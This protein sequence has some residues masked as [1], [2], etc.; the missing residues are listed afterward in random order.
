[1]P[2]GGTARPSVPGR[3]DGIGERSSRV[4]ARASRAV[5]PI[6]AGVEAWPP[7]PSTRSSIDMMPFS[8]TPTTPTGLPMPAKASCAIAP[9]SSTTNH[10]RTPRRSSSATASSAAVPNTSSSQPKESQTSWAGREVPLE[11]GLDGLADPDQAAL[12]VEGAAAP[13]LAVDDRAA[14]RVVL[15]GALD[16]HD[17]EVGHQHDRPRGARAGASGRAARGCAPGSARAA[18]AAAGTGGPAPRRTRR[19]PRCRPARARGRRRSGS[20]RA[21]AASALRAVAPRPL[22]RPCPDPS[23]PGTAAAPPREASRRA[24]AADRRRRT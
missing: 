3:C 12:V 21:P 11:Q 16:R 4:I 20:G 6:R 22:A 9:P 15:P 5:G 24:A 7:R 10:G 2:A 18:R 19:T 23:R 1:M 14:E 17:V 13:D 8:V